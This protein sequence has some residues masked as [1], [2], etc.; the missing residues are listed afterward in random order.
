[1]L[2]PV[3]EDLH[4][5]LLGRHGDAQG[6]ERLLLAHRRRE[7]VMRLR[8]PVHQNR[9]RVGRADHGWPD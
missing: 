2:Q 1:M 4:N 5:L 7:C 6:G 8:R 9:A 3:D